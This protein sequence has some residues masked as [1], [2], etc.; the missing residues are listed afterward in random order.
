MPHRRHLQ[1][2]ADFLV[3]STARARLK[4]RSTR[5]SA[6]PSPRTC[7]SSFLRR[8]AP[9]SRKAP[10]Q[11][12][13]RVENGLR[14]AGRVSAS[15]SSTP[16]PAVSP[17]L[18]EAL[19]DE[20]ERTAG[21]SRSARCHDGEWTTTS[22]LVAGIRRA[23][24]EGALIDGGWCR[25][26]GAA[27]HHPRQR[28]SAAG[29]GEARSTPAPGPREGRYLHELL[30]DEEELG[31]RLLPEPDAGDSVL[32]AWRVI[33]STRPGAGDRVPLQLLLP[34]RRRRGPCAAVW[35]RTRATPR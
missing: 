22:G 2:S 31:F 16:L 20:P 9:R 3:W 21:R 12:R 29:H 30:P 11:A 10:H 18:V 4:S 1:D 13:P 17:A 32:V 8:A 23:Q 26:A 27:E 5:S 28:V 34:R 33:R 24:A 15:P 19:E 35:G 6:A 14:G 25:H 7:C